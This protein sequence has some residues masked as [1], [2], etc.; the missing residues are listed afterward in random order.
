MVGPGTNP[1]W[2]NVSNLVAS[3]RNDGVTATVTQTPGAV[4]YIE[5]G[6]A[7]LTNTPAALLQNHAGN[8]VAPGGEGGT[9]ALA[10]AEFTAE[11][12][13]GWV[14]DPTDPQAYPISTFT[15]MLFYR[16]QEAARAEALRNFVT[17]ALGEGQKMADQLGYIPLPEV[18]ISKV[19]AQIPNIG[20]TPA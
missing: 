1:Q 9:L 10:S 2:P 4:G 6:F 13:R 19:T 11:D 12:M 17:W 18:V 20:S 15:W 8:F 7:K 3:P 16:K 14:T 5:W